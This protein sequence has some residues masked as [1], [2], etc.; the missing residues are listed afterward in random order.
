[1]N[2]NKIVYKFRKYLGVLLLTLFVGYFININFFSHTHIVD[3]VTV[4][5]SHPYSA[6]DDHT[7]SATAISF[8]Q[9]LSH[10]LT[11]T[12]FAVFVLT[13]Y[14]QLYRILNASY[15][16]VFISANNSYYNYSRPPPFLF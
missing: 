9:L 16:K 13:I 14:P 3:G 8:I 4:A 15:S 6:S 7:H 10:F 5:H 2:L 12:A 11:L 1:M